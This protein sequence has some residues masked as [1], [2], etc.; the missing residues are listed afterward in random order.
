M[1]C[2]HQ[3][4]AD[5]NL[6]V[7][8]FA[9]RITRKC[10]LELLDRVEADPEYIEG[11]VAFDDLREVTELAINA[12]DISMFADLMKGIHLRRMQPRKRAVLVPSGNARQAAE[13]YCRMVRGVPGLDIRVFGDIKSALSFLGLS[14]TPLAAHLKSGRILV[15]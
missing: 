4:F 12:D 15:H 6:L 11:M 1:P 5:E 10:V 8:R 7:K 13:Q 14:E 2:E 3:T 9:G